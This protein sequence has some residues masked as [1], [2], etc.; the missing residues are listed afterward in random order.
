MT[1]QPGEF[2]LDDFGL[3][4]ICQME[5]IRE[6]AYRDAVGVWTIGVGHTKGV[7]RGDHITH[8]EAMRLLQEDIEWVERC[9]NREIDVPLTQSQ[10][11]ALGSWVFNLGCGALHKST[12]RKKILNG[13]TRG[14]ADE[15]PK[16]CHAGGRKLKGLVRRRRAER[17]LFLS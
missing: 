9:L 15:L 2:H 1:Q 7:K 11:N 12:L 6:S 10:V 5:G 4:L 16:W 3:E 13:D 17:D 8:D 14:A